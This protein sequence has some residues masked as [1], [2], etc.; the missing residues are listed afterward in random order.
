MEGRCVLPARCVPSTGSRPAPTAA[1]PQPPPRTLHCQ[2]L[3]GQRGGHDVVCHQAGQL[4][5]QV[6][7]VTQQ[8]TCSRR[9]DIHAGW[10]VLRAPT[11]AKPPPRAAGDAAGRRTATCDAPAAHLRTVADEEV[12]P[13]AVAGNQDGHGQRIRVG[14]LVLGARQPQ[15]LL[16]HPGVAVRT[17]DGVEKGDVAGLR[18]GHG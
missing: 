17:M 11:W 12:K 2:L 9:R 5:A 13:G 3:G 1:W 6:A 8:E 15:P 10:A 16:K 18:R 14:Q 7:Q 4:A